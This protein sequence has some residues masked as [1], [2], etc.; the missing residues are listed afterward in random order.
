MS[1]KQF[2]IVGASLAGAKAAETLREQ[3][4]DGR[5]VLIGAECERTHR[6]ERAHHSDLGGHSSL[7]MRLAARAAPSRS[8][9]AVS[10]CARS[11]SAIAVPIDSGV[12][13]S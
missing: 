12:A 4:F 9:S 5:L 6:R 2:V 3:G 13:V 10:T 7:A 11:A 1:D 8:T